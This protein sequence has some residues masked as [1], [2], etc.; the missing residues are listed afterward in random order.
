VRPVDG[1]NEDFRDLLVL[2][3]DEGAEFL[4]VG[5]YAVAFHGAPRATGDLDVLVRATPANAPRVV[6]ALRRFGAPVDGI[7][8]TAQ[9][10]ESPGA[11]F[12]IGHPPRAIDVLTEIS[13]VSFDRAWAGRDRAVIDGR[14][15]GII[16]RADLVANKRAAARLK[17]LA[18][19]EAIEAVPPSGSSG[20]R[21]RSQDA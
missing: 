4:V 7:G 13:G 2:L 14:E 17:D 18:D 11:G 1:L 6:A 10:L 21:S 9:E 20:E 15:V 5:A 8:L 19:V 3:A 12:Q 16:G